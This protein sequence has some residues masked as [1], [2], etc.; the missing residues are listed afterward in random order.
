MSMRR[1]LGNR[2][3]RIV[4]L[5]LF[6]V[7]DKIPK[8]TFEQVV[9]QLVTETQRIYQ[10]APASPQIDAACRKSRCERI[11]RRRRKQ[12]IVRAGL[13]CGRALERGQEFESALKPAKFKEN[14]GDDWVRVWASR[15]SPTGMTLRSAYTRENVSGDRT[16]T[17][18]LAV[19][20][21]A[22]NAKRV[23]WPTANGLGVW[24]PT[25]WVML[26]SFSLHMRTWRRPRQVDQ[27]Q[28]YII[29]HAA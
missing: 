12:A 6:F 5:F 20:A 4:C 22:Y 24:V 13:M 14:Q 21:A 27:G 11:C 16:T 9:A 17:G 3:M 23:A 18:T 25:R 8:P 15:S 19:D 28:S 1:R 7:E 2:L 10:T 29:I 26:R